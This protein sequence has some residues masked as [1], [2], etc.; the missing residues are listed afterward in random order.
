MFRFKLGVQAR[1]WGKVTFC[2]G[3]KE[4]K[5]QRRAFQRVR[6]AH[7][8]ALGWKRSSALFVSSQLTGA[9]GGELSW[10]KV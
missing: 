4:E 2:I 10:E 5:D 1:L 7:V 6:G 3:L 9:Q 8:K